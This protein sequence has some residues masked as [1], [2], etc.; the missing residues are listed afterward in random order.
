MRHHHRWYDALHKG[1]HKREPQVLVTVLSTAGSTPRDA[2]AKMV[3]TAA[4]HFDTI[5]GGH[6]E[7]KAIAR[8][9][10]LLQAGKNTTDVESISLG[11]S[12]GQCCGGA[13]QLLFEVLIPEGQPLLV[14]GAGHVAQHLMPILAPL[15][16]TL[17]WVD[18]RP[19]WLAENTDTRIC[20][21][22]L[23]HPVDAIADAPANAWVLI[24]T[25]NHQ[26]DFELVQASLKRPDIR[27]IGLIGSDTKATRF[28]Q[29]LAHRGWSEH[30]INRVIC[31]VGLSEVPGKQPAEVAVSIAA[32]LLN[33][34]H[35]Q[36][37]AETRKKT[38][39]LNWKTGLTLSNPSRD[40]AKSPVAEIDYKGQDK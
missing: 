32:Q 12:L 22:A 3:V 29:R 16:L 8:A 34:L 35:A 30:D 40:T 4:E 26:L 18:P 21:Q 10:E 27:Y 25:H 38:S 11:A 33:R 14:F 5:G 23:E 39:G 1:Q 17:T 28:Q 7:Y 2:A 20:R 31:P 37:P 9:R 15:D 6:L 36:R 24:I 13:T 19:D